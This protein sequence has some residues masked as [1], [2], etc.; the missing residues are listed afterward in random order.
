MLK[1]LQLLFGEGILQHQHHSKLAPLLSQYSKE[2]AEA[3]LAIYKNN[4]YRSLTDILIDTYTSV[5][6]LIS[7]E[8]FEYLAKQFIGQHPPHNATVS[9]Y[10]ANFPE[11]LAQQAVSQQLPYISDTAKLDWA[12]HAA[13]YQA[14]ATP[15]A[16]ETFAEIDPQTL[17]QCQVTFHPATEILRSNYAIFS[18]HEFL[19][20]E[21]QE[22]QIHFDSPENV[23]I[24]R[25][26]HVVEHYLL[27]EGSDIFFQHLINN[28]SI[29]QA[30]SDAMA[31]H[32]AFDPSQAFSFL[33]QTQAVIH[34]QG[35]A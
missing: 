25:H 10:G 32:S 9:L 1:N 16:P 26:Q 23:L 31:Q 21:N 3:R 27:P 7:R 11:F 5:D 18:I 24:C 35:A 17:M 15:V 19:N 4:Y 2:E 20:S 14:D 8:A 12:L 13:Y 6:Q 22:N 33:I 34:I 29:E 28:Q 30:I